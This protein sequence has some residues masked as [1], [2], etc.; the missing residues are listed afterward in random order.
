MKKVFSLL[1]LLLVMAV[2]SLSLISCGNEK[3]NR[4]YNAAV[5]LDKEVKKDNPDTNLVISLGKEYISALS[6]LN[7]QERDELVLKLEKK[8]L[9]SY[10]DI[11]RLDINAAKKVVSALGGAST[12]LINGLLNAAAKG[13][14]NFDADE[15][16]RQ[17]EDAA[18]DVTDFLN[19]L[20]TNF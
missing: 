7:Q 4:A 17:V 1:S 9:S 16:S 12:S 2:L 13:L 19:N 6:E 8:G 20:D 10:A 5:K 3:V 15:F 14:E 11:A 18:D